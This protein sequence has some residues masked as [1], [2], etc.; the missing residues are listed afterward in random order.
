MSL[1]PVKEYG[2]HGVILCEPAP[3]SLS[4][5]TLNYTDHRCYTLTMQRPTYGRFFKSM[6]RWTVDNIGPN[7]DALDRPSVL[8][9]STRLQL[10]RYSVRKSVVSCTA[11]T[12]QVLMAFF[13]LSP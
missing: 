9:L 1:L 12:I 7:Q 4:I 8:V 3:S 2:R 10:R 11:L 13:E 6:V 5:A